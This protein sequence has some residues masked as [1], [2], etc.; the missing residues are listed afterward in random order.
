LLFAMVALV[1]VIHSL[2]QRIAQRNASALLIFLSIWTFWNY[3]FSP[4]YSAIPS[5][6]LA[7]ALA[8]P[9]RGDSLQASWN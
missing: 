6:V 9:R 3:L 4:L 1:N 2:T 8:L 5:M 7:V